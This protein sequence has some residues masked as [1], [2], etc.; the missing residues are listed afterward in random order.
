MVIKYSIDGLYYIRDMTLVKDTLDMLRQ[1]APIK[2]PQL[3]GHPIH[4]S[5]REPIEPQPSNALAPSVAEFFR[6][7]QQNF[8]VH[9]NIDPT[10]VRRLSEIEAELLNNKS[11]NQQ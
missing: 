11:D 8:Y 5:Q 4:F 9:T 10:K 1:G 6:K 2:M 3:L 7:A